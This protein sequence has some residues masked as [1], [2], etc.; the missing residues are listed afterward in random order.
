M[1][2]FIK[3]RLLFNL[4]VL[5]GLASISG[6]L[7]SVMGAGPA[8]NSHHSLLIN[9]TPTPPVQ[10]VSIPPAIPSKPIP[11][12]STFTQVNVLIATST[13]TP[14]A[15]STST[16][17][18][19]N[20]P[21]ATFTPIPNIQAMAS[22]SQPNLQLKVLTNTCGT[23][24]AQD[25]FE[26]V[27]L[28]SPVTLSDI[29]IKFWAHD[30]SGSNL[31]GAVNTGG[32]LTNP[33]C[34]HQVNGVS[35]SSV[36]LPSCG[37]NANWEITVRNT[38]HTVMSSGVSWTN[39]QTALHLA[40]FS[41]FTPGTASWYSPC[42]P[43]TNYVTDVHYAVYLKGNLLPGFG[44]VPPPCEAV[45]GSQQL[46]GYVPTAVVNAPLVGDLP[47]STLIRLAIG[48][49]LRD[50]QGLQTLIQQLYDPNNPQ[51]R[52]F[53]NTSQFTSAY[54]P[55]P[56]DYQ[57]LKN[58]VLSKGLTVAQT[59]SNN[60]L[61][62]VIGTAADI[63][64]A[65][66]VNLISYKR[67][68]GTVFYSLDRDPSLDLS[69]PI[70]HIMGLDNFSLPRPATTSVNLTTGVTTNN[71]TPLLGGSQG[72]N[73]IGADFRA[74]YVPGLT[75]DGTGQSV[76][77]VEFDSY[78]SGDITS[79]ENTP[80]PHLANNVPTI[81]FVDGVSTSA[82]T[83]TGFSGNYPDYNG[84]G[85]G[86]ILECTMDIEL[87]ISMAPKAHVFVYEGI[88]ND[89]VLA[90]IAAPPVGTPLS[91]QISA[92]WLFG[93]DPNIL[94]TLQ[95]YA[96][97]GQSYF[98]GSGDAGAYTTGVPADSIQDQPLVTSVGGTILT[99]NGPVLPWK[100]ETTW[101]S[102]GASPGAGGGGI[103]NDISIPA[104]QVPSGPNMNPALSLQS[105]TM[106]SIPDV[107]AAAL[108]IFVL[109][110]NGLTYG[111]GGT[112]AATPLWAGFMALV[113]QRAQANG[114]FPVGWAN[115]VLYAIGKGANYNNDFHDINDGTNNSL[116][117]A[118]PVHFKAVN[119]YD[120]ATGWGSFKG[121]NLIADLLGNTSCTN[122]STWRPL[123]T[124]N[125]FS[126][127]A[128]FESLVFNSNLWVIGG[129]TQAPFFSGP[130]NDVYSS[131]NGIT[132]NTVTPAG[133]FAAGGGGSAVVFDS[134]DG[135]GPRMW[136][137]GGMTGSDSTADSTATNNIYTSFDG[138]TWTP[139]TPVGPI[140]S[141][142]RWHTCIVFNGKMWVMG[143][144]DGSS[145]VNGDVWSTSNGI[146]WTN[147]TQTSPYP[148]R[149]GQTCLVFDS[150]DGKGLRMWLI[151]GEI[152]GPTIAGNDVWYSTDGAAWTP[153]TTAANFPVRLLHQ[154]FVFCNKMWV[155][156][157]YGSGGCC[158]DYNDVWSSTNGITWTAATTNAG[159]SLRAMFGALTLNGSLFVFGGNDNQSSGPGLNDVWINP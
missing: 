78:Y 144:W 52:H 92:S 98:N 86:G 44:A 130:L 131:P 118:D 37:P 40:N 122:G 68:D 76:A 80:S 102:P 9:K 63:E 121:Q 65:F 99:T 138:A 55:T 97:Q 139:V 147:V 62:D 94:T 107:S 125:V 100:S 101:N 39:L 20:P 5:V 146:N 66:N 85:L 45:H 148:A 47:G 128:D 153:A 64:K 83:S 117:N 127:R 159:F 23:N 155:V 12:T 82:S 123:T 18:H 59:F 49:P 143:G 79:Y 111:E 56:V 135:L 103:S 11:P 61:L 60:Q 84:Y 46:Q 104:F 71:P 13:F 36:A 38:D 89:D 132:W 10:P 77:M 32:C 35:I 119:G 149:F 150:G 113:N 41:N 4:V 96:A 28:G 43:G 73:F 67:P 137:I 140:F 133:N 126:S 114:A 16:P 93:T 26:V 70:L 22:I 129:Y 108:N 105:T 72:G 19:S 115:P 109:A 157:G 134:G 81:V 31:D 141:P 30:T 3:I 152:G 58:F 7:V 112:S 2:T 51:Y 120:L 14:A 88:Y 21:A 25:F 34:F 48:L 145:S 8:G 27:N 54:G 87:I 95:E 90:S 15:T 53:L 57:T 136:L 106:R 124:S 156:G 75:E 24:Q 116:N 110:N 142:R 50:Q 42:L 33:S 1:G 6:V 91:N 29:T 74:A 17:T 69:L 154:S 158:N 151:A